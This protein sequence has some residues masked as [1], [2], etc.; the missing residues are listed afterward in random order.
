MKLRKLM[1]PNFQAAMI[2]LNA[3]KVPIKVTLILTNMTD[4]LEAEIAR[5][6]SAKMKSIT[7]SGIKK[8]DGTLETD[9]KG[10]IKLSDADKTRIEKEL[11]E[12]L[13]QEIDMPKIQLADLG[14]RAVLSTADLTQ[15]RGDI[16]VIPSAPTPITEES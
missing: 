10:N 14:D 11:A 5:F 3:Q 12:A 1:D 9:E 8:E 7:E 15:L 4:K 6:N 13:D 16:I 2:E